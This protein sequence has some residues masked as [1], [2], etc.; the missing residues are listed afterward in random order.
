MTPG[1]YRLGMKLKKTFRNLD[2]LWE[3]MHEQIA[4]H[5]KYK[6]VNIYTIDNSEYLI[7]IR[8]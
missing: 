1:L 7:I 3:W 8:I 2:E 4:I 5:P 6:S